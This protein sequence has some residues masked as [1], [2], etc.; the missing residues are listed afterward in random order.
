MGPANAGSTDP[1]G[2]YRESM[3]TNPQTGRPSWISLGVAVALSLTWFLVVFAQ[4]ALLGVSDLGQSEWWPAA[5][6][7]RLILG[8]PL[9][10]IVIPLLWMWLRRREH[11]VSW[12]KATGWR[13]PTTKLEW[14]WL[15]LLLAAACVGLLYP[16]SWAQVAATMATPVLILVALQAPLVEETL[17]RGLFVHVMDRGRWRRWMTTVL[18]AVC[19]AL[20]HVVSFGPSG[21]LTGLLSI[22]LMIIPRYLTGGIIASVVIHLVLNSG[23]ANVLTYGL[24]LLVELAALVAHLVVRRRG[25]R[26][27]AA[28][29]V[30]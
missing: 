1:F 3:D 24:V 20:W 15:V 7:W 18:G 11:P 30:S 19:F 22:P 5:S 12:A 17:M 4:Q 14:L 2:S 21:W 13:L 10:L 16:G 9:Y 26:A 25:R 27:D 8:L 6:L 28:T 23:G 29:P